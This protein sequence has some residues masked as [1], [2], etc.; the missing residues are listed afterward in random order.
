MDRDGE[1]MV[2]DTGK[3]RKF[4]TKNLRTE[5]HICLN[6]YPLICSGWYLLKPK[7]RR[8]K[9][10]IWVDIL[11]ALENKPMKITHITHAVNI[12]GAVAKELLDFMLSQKLVG[13][14]FPIGR[15]GLH[16]AP[17]GKHFKLT[18]RGK[19]TLKYVEYV[20]A[21]TPSE[22]W[23]EQTVFYGGTRK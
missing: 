14:I 3:E 7:A 20:K 8:S 2:L 23:C 5:K 17:T 16:F 4:S 22:I 12:N 9:F 15:K 19:R 21:T 6:T 18:D 13:T 1:S 10:E 11:K